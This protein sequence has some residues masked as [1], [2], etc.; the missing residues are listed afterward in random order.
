MIRFLCGY[1][2]GTYCG[3][4][5]DLKPYFNKIFNELK[6]IKKQNR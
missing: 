2:L 5:Y 3:T 4:Y 1:I 6:K